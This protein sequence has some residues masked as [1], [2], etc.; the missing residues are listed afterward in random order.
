MKDFFF[1]LANKIHISDKMFS[2]LMKCG[3]FKMKCRG[4]IDITVG[5]LI[6]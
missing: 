2:S 1:I 6:P 5:F 3:K 4:T